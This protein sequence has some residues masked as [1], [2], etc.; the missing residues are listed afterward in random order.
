MG[1]VKPCLE[2]KHEGMKLSI[3]KIHRRRRSTGSTSKTPL[4]VPSLQAQHPSPASGN[5][6]RF[7][8]GAPP[9]LHYLIWPLRK[10]HS[11]FNK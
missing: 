11:S 10:S 2:E 8:G 1:F 5:V 9:N 4:A 7:Q 6:V 3:E